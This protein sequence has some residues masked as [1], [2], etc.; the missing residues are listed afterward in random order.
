MGWTFFHREPGLKT[1]DVFKKELGERVLDG[2][3]NG[4]EFYLLYQGVK[5]GETKGGKLAIVCLT[6]C[7]SHDFFNFGYKDMSEDMGPYYYNC[8]E[9]ILK[10]LDPLEQLWEPNSYAYN[11]A[12]KWREECGKNIKG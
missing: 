9:R 2:A 4:R 8:P 1:L 7:K 12:K 10:Q 11:T 5:T 3:A 6:Q